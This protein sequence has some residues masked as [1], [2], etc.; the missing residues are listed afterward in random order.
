MRKFVLTALS[1]A[2]LS[3]VGGAPTFAQ[4]VAGAYLAGRHAA[5][6]SDYSEAARYYTSALARDPGNV[7]KDG[8]LGELGGQLGDHGLPAGALRDVQLR[9]NGR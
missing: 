6:N 3:S 8:Y 9:R 5:V 4:S 7:R 2:I 1:A